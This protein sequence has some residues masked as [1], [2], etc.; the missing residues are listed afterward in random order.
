MT[1]EHAIQ[2]GVPFP[3]LC[4]LALF[5]FGCF[6]GLYIA[7][8]LSVRSSCSLL[9]VS[10]LTFLLFTTVVFRKS[11]PEYQCILIPFYSY[12]TIFNDPLSLNPWEVAL[13]VVVFIP[14]GFLAGGIAKN[15]GLVLA[16]L[17]GVSTSLIIEFL[18]LVLKRGVF[19]VDDLIHN[20]V[21]CLIG[22]GLYK[23]CIKILVR[24]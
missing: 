18:Q 19:E 24:F 23:S 13:N 21:G 1:F 7:K 15:K 11:N 16:C 2:T 6:I 8:Q 17:I 14:V 20:N 9:L 12:F 10:Y 22:Y 5:T 4:G 3:A